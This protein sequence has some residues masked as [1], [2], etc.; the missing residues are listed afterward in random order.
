[1]AALVQT[2]W[3]FY[4]YLIRD[5]YVFL[6]SLWGIFIAI[7]Q[8]LVY[9]WIVDVINFERLKAVNESWPLI[10]FKSGVSSSFNTLRNLPHAVISSIVNFTKTKIMR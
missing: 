9:F 3:A 6:P 2:I 10:K 5:N 4:G 8:L 7:T 1:M